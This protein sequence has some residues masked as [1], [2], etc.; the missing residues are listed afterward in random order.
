M[1]KVKFE[2][3]EQESVEITKFEQIQDDLGSDFPF[4]ALW[5]D[6]EPAGGLIKFVPVINLVV[7][8]IMFILVIFILTKK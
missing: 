8:I 7:S 5:Q 1:E 6:G 3:P 2:I 4:A